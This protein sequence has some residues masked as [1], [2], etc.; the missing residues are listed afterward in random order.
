MLGQRR[1]NKKS[2]KEQ[3]ICFTCRTGDEI[4][5]YHKWCKKVSW[6]GVV[7]ALKARGEIIAPLMGDVKIGGVMKEYG[8]TIESIS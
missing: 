8:Q 5:S 7:I 4:D 2:M 1:G 3:C 6:N